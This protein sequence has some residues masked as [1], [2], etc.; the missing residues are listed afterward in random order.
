M[1]GLWSSPA[2]TQK[3]HA[4]TE[5]SPWPAWLVILLWRGSAALKASNSVR[6]PCFGTAFNGIRSPAWQPVRMLAVALGRVP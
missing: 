3:S 6:V 5:G 2:R 4:L 1:R